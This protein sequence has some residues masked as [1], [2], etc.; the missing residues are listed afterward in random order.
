MLN[1]KYKTKMES[2]IVQNTNEIIQSTKQQS[3][4]IKTPKKKSVRV[5]KVS[6][7]KWVFEKTLFF[8]FFFSLFDFLFNPFFILTIFDKW[9]FCFLE[10]I[11]KNSNNTKNSGKK[12]QIVIYNTYFQT[13]HF[14]IS[15][16]LKKFICFSV[17]LLPNQL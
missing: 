10:I 11:E 15:F 17:F 14:Q 4:P 7:K 12:V 16:S 9:F 5:N 1:T 2:E 13:S 6:Q 3:K 8:N